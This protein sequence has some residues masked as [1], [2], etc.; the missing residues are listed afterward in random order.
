MDRKHYFISKIVLAAFSFLLNGLFLIV[1]ARN[2]HL[3]RQ[4]RI[5]YHVANLA[6]ADTMYGLSRFC[7]FI[8]LLYPNELAIVKSLPLF[9]SMS[10]GFYLASETAVLLMSIERS[11]VITKPLTWTAILP[12]KRMLLFIICSWIAVTLLAVLYY[13]FWKPSFGGVAVAMFILHLVLLLFAGAV[14]IYMFK[15]LREKDG[16]A[17]IHEQ[18]TWMVPQAHTHQKSTQLK[19]K[20]SILVLWLAFIMIGTCLPNSLKRVVIAICL[21]YKLHCN[22]L[23]YVRVISNVFA[24]LEDLNYLV[25]PFVYIWRDRIYRNAFY[26]TFKIK[27]SF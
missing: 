23:N 8:V 4:K 27:H 19:H 22:F 13:L 12:R 9:E 6:F 26:R 10:A 17:D 1:L 5:T 11:I 16:L 20:A 25:N 18:S 14:N 2:R 3:V 24:I 15:K 21:N 7:F